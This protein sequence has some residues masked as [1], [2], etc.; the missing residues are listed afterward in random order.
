MLDT[1]NRNHLTLDFLQ[2]GYL[3]IA[4]E[5]FLTDRKASGCAKKTVE[6]YAL[7]LN[8][9]TT[10]CDSHAIT[11]IQEISADFLRR[12]LLAYS[13]SHNPGG[14]HAAF[15]TLRVF[16]R[17]LEFEEVMP[18]DWINPIHKVRA[19]KVSKE[20][21]NPVALEDVQALIDSCKGGNYAERDKSIFLCLLDTGVRATELSNYP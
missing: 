21:I 18:P 7:H 15:R 16:F 2:G 10:H 20:P 8:Q 4:M 9:F 6:F 11:L 3:A 17:W 12:Y 5:S 1:K 19:P 13:E 14:T